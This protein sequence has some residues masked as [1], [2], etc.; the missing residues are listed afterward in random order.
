MPVNSVSLLD[1]D[2]FNVQ[3]DNATRDERISLSYHR[4][5]AIARAY[6]FNTDDVLRLTG[7]FWE[8][9][10]DL[11]HTRDS[12]AFTL[13]AIQ[14][15]LCAGTLAPFLKGRADLRS[16]M[17]K[18]LSFEVSGQFLLTE[19]GHGLDAHALETVAVL[20][21]GGDFDLHTPHP[22]AAKYMPPTSPIPGFPR[23]GIVIARLLVDGEDRGVRPFIVWLNDGWRMCKGVSAKVLP[24]RAG[25]KPLDHCI[26]T[27]NHVRL[28]RSALLGDVD[29]PADLRK[30][31]Q[32]TIWR[33]HIGTLSLT[34]VLI[35]TLKRSVFVAGKYSLRRHIRD[36]N[37]NPRPI[38]SFRTQQ[39]PVLHT[40]AQIAVFEPYAQESI[41]Q[42][43]D[44]TIPYSM[45]QG[46][47]AAFKAVLSQASQESLF[48]LAERCGA[49]GL[50]GYNN[51]IDNQLEVRGSSIAEGDTLV[52]SIKLASELLLGRYNMPPAK[53]PSYLLAIYETQL[54]QHTRN[55]LRSFGGGHRTEEFNTRILP[56]CQTLVEAIGHRMAYEAALDAAVS[57]D[58]L[59]LYEA[60][61]VLRHSGW[62]AENTALDSE[63]QLDM[64]LR[65]M[66]TILPRLEQLLDSTG[67]D[68]YCTAPIV[69]NK[70]WEAF[71]R[72]LKVHEG[73]A[74][75][76]VQDD[77]VGATSK[78]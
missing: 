37:N 60:G 16:L 27:F 44:S 62:F 32:S 51:I 70:S 46:V 69:S 56:R 14:Y 33:V 50:F 77:K 30:N 31:F 75:D 67:A 73:N 35:P 8:F 65:A 53:Y 9:H 71:T 74:S 68:R 5:R 1:S 12:A 76:G 58:L 47:A 21:P 54:F 4:A 28:A 42:Y 49:Q 25:S 66:N 52:L 24:E 39:R 22:D 43:T 78:L 10:Q 17:E 63:S 7:K 72:I 34:T 55:I 13:L 20:L 19:V 29:K 57:P 6:A 36:P 38:I 18:L 11:I 3:A 26:T 41:R 45:R 59:A 40:L 23:V 64:E 15:N 2:L 48:A 61:V